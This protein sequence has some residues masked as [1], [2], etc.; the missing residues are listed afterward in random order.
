MGRV[1]SLA[2]NTAIFAVCNFTSKLLVFFMLPFYT[3]VLSKEEFGT[4]DLITTIV[5][6]LYP[7]LT[8]SIADGC[9]RYALD[10][11][12]DTKKVFSIGVLVTVLGAVVLL[13]ALPILS[14]IRFLKGYLLVFVCLFFSNIF[15]HLFS[16]F[17]RGIQKVRL[18]GIAGV[19]SSFT[20]VGCNILFLFVFHFGAQGYVWSIVISNVISI[21]I[22]FFGGKMFCYLT[23]PNDKVLLKEMLGYSL[24][25]MPNSL[26]W[27]INHSA[28]R[29]I[30]NYF[31]GVADVG[32][33]SAA[34]KMPSMIDTFRGVF[35]QAWQLSSITELENKDSAAFFK[36]M[37]QTYHTFII[38]LTGFLI[39]F[40]QVI[41]GILYSDEF[42]DAWRITPLLFVG[43]MFGSL[44]AYFSPT[45]LAQRKTK[46]LFFSTFLGA[47]L[48]IALN[49][50]L[51]PYWG[52]MGTA[53]TSVISNFAIFLYLHIDSRK[54]L[55]FQV[56]NFPYYCSFVVIVVQAAAITFLNQPPLGY[57]SLICLILVLFLV[58]KD[59]CFFAK[60]A[61]PIISKKLNRK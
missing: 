48:T 32:L 50:V 28:N 29:Y 25:L 35:I 56:D 60:M 14:Q 41:G 15:H 18:V 20:V 37:Y 39:I 38:L 8:L 45:Y 23:I 13:L 2:E 47:V 26:S 1:K 44:I 34:S 36:G 58:R 54:Y 57:L 9:M 17:S 61:S 6:L 3:S 33:Y 49:F 5:G 59:I 4:A 55:V 46:I 27:W 22:L 31:C 43:V 19:I 53:I 11:N 21:L 10:K 12:V 52:I 42:L 16:L 51:I 24:P 40:S 7:V 30:L